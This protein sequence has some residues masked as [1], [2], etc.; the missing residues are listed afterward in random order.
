M[1]NRPNRGKRLIRLLVLVLG[2]GAVMYILINHFLFHN[3]FQGPTF[4]L[5]LIKDDQSKA[6]SLKEIVQNALVGT[7]GSYGIVIKNLK[8]GEYYYANEHAVYQSGSLYKLWV[9]AAAFAQ[10]QGGELKESEVLSEDVRVLNDKFNISSDSAELS[11]GTITL[12]VSSALEKMI[13]I[14]HNYDALL[15]AERL[16][17]S[18]L[19]DFLR[20][21]GFQ[22]SKIGTSGEAP[23]SSAYDMALFFEKLYKGELTNQEYTNRMLDL[24]KAQQL[25]D[26]FPKY[27]PEETIIAHKTGELDA[28]THDAGIIFTPKGDYIIVILSASDTPSAAEERIAQLSKDVYDF[29][30]N[31]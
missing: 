3:S 19:A 15:L 21:N 9:M 13:T 25:N 4:N 11:D 30:Q 18:Y 16:Q 27:L 31:K 7:K 26:K 8:T 23:T 6:N 24:L 20:Q 14:S 17:L 10:I 5:S 2:A 29:F 1:R 28:F 12:T 22:E